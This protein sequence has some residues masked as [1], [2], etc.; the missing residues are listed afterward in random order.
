MAEYAT[1]G[2]LNH[3][4]SIRLAPIGCNLGYGSTVTFRSFWS[5]RVRRW[6]RNGRGGVACNPAPISQGLRT[7]DEA[8]DAA[9]P[10]EAGTVGERLK[11]RVRA[12]LHQPIGRHR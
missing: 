6:T 9:A 5:G 1:E 11:E 2:S 4:G 8:G 7:W 3:A 12:V 10:G